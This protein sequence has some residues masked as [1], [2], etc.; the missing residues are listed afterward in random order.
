MLT[1][2]ISLFPVATAMPAGPLKPVLAPEIVLAGGIF[3]FSVLLYT[4][5]KL[6][7]C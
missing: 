7:D 4:V 5:I 2:N 1:T 6:L 3:P